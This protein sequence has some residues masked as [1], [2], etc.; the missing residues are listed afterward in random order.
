MEISNNTLL[1]FP[2]ELLFEIFKHFGIHEREES[3]CSVC[4]LFHVTI[5]TPLSK[6]RIFCVS[7][8]ETNKSYQRNRE[9]VSQ[10]FWVHH[11]PLLEGIEVDKKITFL[12]KDEFLD[13]CKNP[14][15]LI[16]MSS[17]L[18]KLDGFYEN[19]IHKLL[20]MAR[21]SLNITILSLGQQSQLRDTFPKICKET[22]PYLKCLNLNSSTIF[23]MK[24]WDFSGLPLKRFNMSRMKCYPGF[25]IRMPCG[26][27]ELYINY[28]QEMIQE[29]IKVDQPSFNVEIMLI[30]CHELDKW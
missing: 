20:K 24:F 15:S 4:K 16:S 6:Y 22:V 23:S 28:Q 26:L 25:Q 8:Y 21:N 11:K 7:A 9:S 1:N 2:E 30:D 27:R 13:L 10:L 19:E 18:L 5:K 3:L 14:P 29:I 12:T 17:I